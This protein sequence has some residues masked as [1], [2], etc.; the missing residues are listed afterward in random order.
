MKR[1]VTKS[2][3]LPKKLALIVIKRLVGFV[4]WEGILGNFTMMS[5]VISNLNWG[6]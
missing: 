5:N 3:M 4:Q 2:N 6:G 1:Q